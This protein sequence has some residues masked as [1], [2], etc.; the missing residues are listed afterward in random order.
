MEI[1]LCDYDFTA[2][3]EEQSQGYNAVSQLPEI[4]QN[5]LASCGAVYYIEPVSQLSGSD[6]FT[7]RVRLQSLWSRGTSPYV[8]RFRRS[9][10]DLPN[11]ARWAT[12]ERPHDYLLLNGSMQYMGYVT[13]T[14]GDRVAAMD[15]TFPSGVST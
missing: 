15:F 1:T 6:D 3:Y 12:A 10:T 11:A 8:S 13:V 4:S 7:N 2:L 5:D 9:I 14:D